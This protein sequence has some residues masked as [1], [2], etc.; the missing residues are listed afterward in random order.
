[1]SKKL[2]IVKT[3]RRFFN[4]P[5]FKDD[6]EKTRTA[7]VLNHVLSSA[8][9]LLL[10]PALIG[11][12]LIYS[13][14]I[15]TAIVVFALFSLI[16]VS[17][18]LMHRGHVR[19]AGLFLVCTLWITFAG[20][21]ILGT[22]L[23]DINFIFII[24]V[25]VLAGLL[26]GQGAAM[27]TVFISMFAGLLLVI[28]EH[29]GYLPIY[30]FPTPPMARWIE[31]S[32]GL[33]L[34]ATTLNLAI[35]SRDDALSLAK[36]QIEERKRAEEELTKK[37]QYLRLITDNIQDAIRVIDLKTLKYTYT[38]PYV[39]HL[40]GI[41]SI[42]YI[43]NTMGFNLDPDVRQHLL[44]LIREEIEND[45][46]RDANRTRMVEFFEKNGQTGELIYTENKASLIRDSEG[47]PTAIL[48]ITRDITE[49]RQMEEQRRKL[50]DRLHRAEKMEAIGTLAGGVAHDLNNVLGVL[51]GYSELL[52]E[53]IPEKSS[54]RMFVD[55]I[56]QSS[57]RGAAII[58]DLLTLA[59]RGVTVSTVVNLNKVVS[60]HFKT[61]EFEKLKS[62]NPH[63]R[64]EMHLDK[65]L[66]NIKGSPLHLG[67]TVMNLIS[68]A[69]EAIAGDGLITIQTE[70]R[71]FDEPLPGYDGMRA[72]DYV[73]LSVSDTGK[74]ISRDDLGKIFEPFYTKKVMGRSGTGLGLAVVWG[75]VQDHSGCIDVQSDE[76]RGSR[77]TLY[78]P[79]TTEAPT[80]IAE[81]VSV[82]AYIGRGESI[83]VVD[84]VK[85]Q[86]SLATSMLERLGY[87]VQT[88]TSGEA[89]IAYLE[90]ENADLV[91][92]DMIMDPGLDGLSTYEK[93]LETNPR[94][95]AVIVSGFSETERV[96]KA[97]AL[98][99]GA[100]IRKPYVLERIGVA[101]RKELDRP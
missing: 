82:E 24:S 18:Y 27:K 1:M 55:N 11:V 36:D 51:V 13:R 53:K 40:F 38:N 16:L 80:K 68:N 41:P 96:R 23:K 4:P 26:L 86:R 20:M 98:G 10:L 85:E 65:N 100:Y 58:Q 59:R 6:E 15:G 79:V 46:Q 67:K 84:D 64:F 28:A 61:L 43:G 25:T 49:R 5:V 72:G 71:S 30:Y 81:A 87:K 70:N 33:I 101:I 39:Q 69:A 50:E 91:V 12:P 44:Q 75:T 9:V 66:M 48:T 45:A 88:V 95:K 19:Q 29:Y 52:L 78:F 56:L 54:L 47:R 62:Y 73:V 76:G 7:K 32:L 8:M 97:Q 90:K 42:N 93:I 2:D 34:T 57:T 22:G 63:L 21:I 35:R 74:G 94:Q 92:L 77:F 17:K 99:A 89:A 14:K 60:D 3:V 83:L 37:E 31:L